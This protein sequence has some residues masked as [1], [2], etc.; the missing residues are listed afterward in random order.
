MVDKVENPD[1]S[2]VV[3]RLKFAT[4]AFL[5]MLADPFAYIYKKEITRKGPAL[6]REEHPGL[7]PVQVRRL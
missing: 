2:T 7:R 6:V 5:P 1:P 3:F 4:S